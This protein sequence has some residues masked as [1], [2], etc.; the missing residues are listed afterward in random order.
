MRITDI[1]IG[2][3]QRKDL[4]DIPGLAASIASVSLLQPPVV[5]PDNILVSGLRRLTACRRLGW[6]AIPVNVAQTLEDERRML[7]AERDENT[8]R[9]DYTPSEAVA[10]GEKLEPMER[11]AAEQRMLAGE[12]SEN[13]SQGRAPQSLDRV[14]SAVGMSRPTYTKAKEIVESAAEKPEGFG[15]LVELMDQKSV[16]AAYKEMRKRELE[17]EREVISQNAKALPASDRWTVGVA[18]IRTYES[19]RQFDFIITDPPYPREYLPLYETLAIRADDWLKPGGLLLAMCGQ[20]YLAEIMQML[21]LHL[22]YYWTGCYLTPGQPTPLRHRQVNTTWKPVLVFCSSSA[23][24]KGKIFG[25]VWKSDAS[26]KDHHEWGQ[27]ISGMQALVDQVCLPGQTIFDPFCGAGTTGIA[28][29][30]RG[31]LFCG[32]DIDEKTVDLARGRLHDET[33]AG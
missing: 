3:R 21:S 18:D 27:S 24:Y 13:F 25:D 15:D 7:Q 14:A 10:I 12:P 30:R 19:D 6:D 33:K 4:G 28:A 22:D 16:D 23:P 32:I 31:C 29:L 11:E 8:C 20:S 5:R 9:K 26:D 17:A 1:I 2:E